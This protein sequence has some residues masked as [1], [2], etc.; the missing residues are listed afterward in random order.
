M[1]RWKRSVYRPPR[2]GGVLTR[3]DHDGLERPPR[4]SRNT[5]RRKLIQGE[6]GFACDFVSVGSHTAA[7]LAGPGYRDIKFSFHSTTLKPGGTFRQ[8][9]VHTFQETRTAET[10]SADASILAFAA[11]GGCR[12]PGSAALWRSGFPRHHGG[13]CRAVCPLARPT[14]GICRWLRLRRRATWGGV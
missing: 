5:E 7:L 6:F 3:R 9:T 11:S 13:L 8:T 4:Q 12:L 10:G 1:V 14:R 2:D